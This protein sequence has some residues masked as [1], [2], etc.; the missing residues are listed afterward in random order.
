MAFTYVTLRIGSGYRTAT[1][2]V[3]N[4]RIRLAPLVEMVNGTSTVA[5]EVSIPLNTDGTTKRTVA[6]TTDPATLPVGNTY[7]VNVEVAGQTVHSFTA[8][9]PHDAG[10]TVDLSDLVELD[11]APATDP[12]GVAGRIVNLSS[13]FAVMAKS[14]GAIGDNATNDTTALASALAAVPT[15]G[16][17]H[18]EPN[19]TYMITSALTGLS[20]KAIDGHGSTIRQA[21]TS[22]NVLT[23]VDVVNFSLRDITLAGATDS[24]PASTGRGISITR[25]VRNDTFRVNLERVIVH[26]HGGDGINISNPITSHFENVEVRN[27]LGHGFNIHGVNGGAAGTSCV[28]AGTYANTNLLAGY[29][30]DTMAYCSFVGA[31]ADGNGIGYNLVACQGIAFSGCGAEAQLDNSGTVAG[32][33]GYSWRISGGFGITLDGCWTLAQPSIALWVTGSAQSVVATGFVENSPGGTATACIQTDSG[34]SA[35]IIHVSNATANSLAGTPLVV[36][37][38]GGLSVPGY[39]YATGTLQ[40]DGAATLGSTLRLI[41]TAAPGV[42]VGGGYLYVESGALRYRGSSGTITALGPA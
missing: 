36:H 39:V 7:R 1:G 8:A 30:L 10:S 34:T 25:S 6:A 35:T 31:A 32:Y 29:H 16:T 26:S 24:S 42:P 22:A 3:A 23:G 2:A 38:G 15:N 17:L 28:F 33:A 4:A 5:A 12:S 13:T 9:I 37:D 27:C 40:A 20:N 14:Y 19:K 11:T 18:L 21:T 41:N